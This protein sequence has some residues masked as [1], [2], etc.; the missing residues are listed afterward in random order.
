MKQ[1]NTISFAIY[2][3]LIVFFLLIAGVLDNGNFIFGVCVDNPVTFPRYPKRL[4]TEWY[5]GGYPAQPAIF[6]DENCE[7]TGEKV[8]SSTT[9]WGYMYQ[10]QELIVHHVTDDGQCP[11]CQT[12]GIRDEIRDVGS[13]FEGP[14]EG[15]TGPWT[16]CTCLP[17]GIV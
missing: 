2:L 9:R 7:D 10:N 12:T 5:H 14:V 4:S 13:P 1:Y 6:E 17:G 3:K 16:G 8:C 11:T 15:P